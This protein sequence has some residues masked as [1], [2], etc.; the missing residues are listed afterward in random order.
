MVTFSLSFFVHS[1]S[2]TQTHII[3]FPAAAV[4]LPAQ[5]PGDGLQVHEVA[6]APPGALPVKGTS[7]C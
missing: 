3:P 2:H 1:H 6:E 5:L 4:Q 7:T